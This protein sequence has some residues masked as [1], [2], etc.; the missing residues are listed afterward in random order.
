MSKAQARTSGSP[1][2]WKPRQYVVLRN[3]SDH[4]VALNLPT[5][6]Q[7]VDRGQT[8]LVPPEVA[9]LP[10]VADLVQQGVLVIEKR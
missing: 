9:H 4:H 7:R 1:V 6:R 3:V 8:L 5:G 2:R 10:Q